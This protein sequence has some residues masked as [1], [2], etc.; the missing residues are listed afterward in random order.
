MVSIPEKKTAIFEAVIELGQKGREIGSLKISEIAEHAGIGKGTVYEYFPS[1]EELLRDAMH[2]F[3]N[4]FFEHI[5]KDLLS[6]ERFDE[7]W[8][9]V[10]G[11]V[12]RLLGCSI[13]LLTGR[14]CY[15]AES[16]CRL[17][18]L[19]Q[20]A[21]EGREMIEQLIGLM[22]DAALQ[23]GLISHRPEADYAV[24]V[25]IGCISALLQRL[26]LEPG[27]EQMQKVMNDCRRMFLA[28]LA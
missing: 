3:R 24:T 8:E 9:K 14:G 5:R 17:D 19:E 23:D 10:E 28:S 7:R 2:Y 26:R 11:I 22:V 27:E 1:R 20:S 21:V 13:P 12:R 25:G 15:T 4:K 6:V 18:N 16:C